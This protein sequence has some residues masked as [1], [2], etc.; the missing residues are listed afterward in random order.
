MKLTNR[1]PGLVKYRLT[2]KNY[3]INRINHPDIFEIAKT[4]IHIRMCG[5]E[6]VSVSPNAEGEILVLKTKSEVRKALGG[7]FDVDIEECGV[8][9]YK[10]FDSEMNELLYEE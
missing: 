2:V 6:V 7:W 9:K 8:E 1:E 5:N 4:E 10:L 3:I